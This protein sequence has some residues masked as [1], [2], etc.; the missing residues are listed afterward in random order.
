[1]KGENHKWGLYSYTAEPPVT[2]FP[3]TVHR[4]HDSPSSSYEPKE[5]GFPARHVMM[6]FAFRWR[7]SCFQWDLPAPLPLPPVDRARTTNPPE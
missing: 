6:D 2:P 1:M 4:G 3:C 5:R 7:N